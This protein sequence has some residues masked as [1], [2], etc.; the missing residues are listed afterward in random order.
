[1]E[2]IQA[3]IDRLYQQKMQNVNHAQLLITV[4]LL[5]SELL[6]LQQKNGTLGTSKVAVT[7]P[8]NMNFAEE[9]IRS[10]ASEEKEKPMEATSQKVEEAPASVEEIKSYSLRKPQLTEEDYQQP[11]QS[12]TPPAQ[13]P[14]PAI[15][16]KYA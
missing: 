9:V 7:L 10:V 16:Q 4:E 3:L 11:A 1:M 12:Y 14:A 8:V 15:V 5:R 6:N 2:R 13:E